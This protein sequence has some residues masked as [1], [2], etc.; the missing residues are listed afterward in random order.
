M[1][2]VCVALVFSTR[3][4]LSLRITDGVPH[5]LYI[6]IYIGFASLGSGVRK[7]ENVRNEMETIRMITRFLSYR[8]SSFLASSRSA[9]A[10]AS[11]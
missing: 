7:R 6:Y 2:S 10:S 11:A 5:S 3:S 1:I 4:W 9:A 8:C